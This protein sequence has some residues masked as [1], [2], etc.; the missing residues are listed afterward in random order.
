MSFWSK[1]PPVAPSREVRLVP[2]RAPAPSRRIAM[3]WRRS[4]A[5]SEFLVRFAD[6]FRE[7]PA[8]LLDTGALPDASA[9]AG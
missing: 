5:M 7:L 9:A 4:S 2:F 8:E 1:K 3:V 6:V